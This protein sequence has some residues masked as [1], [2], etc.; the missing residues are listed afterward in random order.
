M[1][2]LGSTGVW[3]LFWPGFAAGG[4]YKFRVHGAD[5][6]GAPN[7]R[8][9]GVRHRGAAGHGVG[10]FTVATTPGATPTG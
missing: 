3:E 8:P 1:R 4:L 9:D 7:G 5:G 2:A 6:V 10:V